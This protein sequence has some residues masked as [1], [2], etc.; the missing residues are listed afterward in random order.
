[1][2]RQTVEKLITDSPLSENYKK[3]W[4]ETLDYLN[5]SELEL[6]KDVLENLPYSDIVA[7]GQ[8]LEKKAAEY[9]A[10]EERE[11]EKLMQANKNNTN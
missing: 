10:E 3:I 6:M 4:I 7:F 11:W 8:L 1:M 5:Q 9:Q 2:L